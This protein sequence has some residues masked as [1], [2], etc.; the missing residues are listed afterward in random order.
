MAGVHP[1]VLVV[2]V[3]GVWDHVWMGRWS[4]LHPSWGW[5]RARSSEV[6]LSARMP[7]P[8]AT[9]GE[10]AWSWSVSSEMRG[11]WKARAWVVLLGTEV[12]A[13]VCMASAMASKSSRFSRIS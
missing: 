13:L 6:A 1:E 12:P 11:E 9:A 4:G 7:E 8:S 2:G 5:A 10:W 3:V